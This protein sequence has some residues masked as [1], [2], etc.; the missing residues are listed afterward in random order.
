MH[1]ESTQPGRD[2]PTVADLEHKA[3]R[4]VLMVLTDEPGL[5]H[6]D[7]IRRQVF[8]PDDVEDA[9]G[10]LAAYGLAHRIEDFAFATRV[11]LRAQR[12]EP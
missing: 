7:E 2:E 10:R 6:L 12:Y 1:D 11:A 5:W 3:E 4:V 8:Q 9:I